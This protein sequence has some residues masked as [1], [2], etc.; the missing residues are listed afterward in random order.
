MWVRKTK[1]E[2]AQDRNRVRLGCGW[3]LLWGLFAF[4]GAF[5]RSV[6]AAERWSK[7]AF[8]S[9]CFGAIVSVV[10]YLYRLCFGKQKG[11]DLG[12]KLF[13]WVDFDAWICSKCHSVKHLCGS[14]LCECGGTFEPIETW[15][16]VE[17]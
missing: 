2:I 1:D 8:N 7:A 5:F 4:V 15:K 13:V 14:D 6:I 9:I 3:P 10:I 11:G 16:W 12:G 17:E